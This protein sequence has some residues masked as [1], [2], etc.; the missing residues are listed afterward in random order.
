MDG[1]LERVHLPSA[2][3]PLNSA[4]HRLSDTCKCYPHYLGP[5]CGSNYN[6][7]HATPDMLVNDN[8]VFLS[9]NRQNLVPLP[10]LEPIGR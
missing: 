1:R 7:H 4:Q 3:D 5:V 8:Q 9:S 2:C 10:E 6:L